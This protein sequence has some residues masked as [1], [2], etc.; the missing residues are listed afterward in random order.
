MPWVRFKQDFDW[1]VR[2]QVVIAYKADQVHLVRTI[3][4][5]KAV[6]EGKA[7]FID[8]PTKATEDGSR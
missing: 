5:E 4:A 7:V 6:K 3:C 1:Q 8:R 2:P